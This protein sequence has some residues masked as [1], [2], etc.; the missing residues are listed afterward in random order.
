MAYHF[1]ATL[2]RK[3]KECDFSEYFRSVAE[4]SHLEKHGGYLIA[5]C[6]HPDHDDEHPSFRIW[7]NP[8]NTWSWCCMSC[9]NGKKDL[10]TKPGMRN[11]GT[12]IIA[13]VQWMSDYKGSNHI[14]TFEEAVLKILAFYHL[15]IPAASFKKMSGQELYFQKL[16]ALYHRYLLLNDSEPKRYLVSRGLSQQDVT[17]FQIGSDGDRLIFPLYDA[18]RTLKGF[19]SRTVCGEEPKYIHSSA[20]EGFIKSE[21]LYGLYKFDHSIH[22]AYVT[23]GVIDV[24]TATRYG[25][26][27]V[28]AC[29]GTSFMDSHARL[30]KNNGIQKIIFVFDGDNAGR[31][32][33]NNAIQYARKEGLSVSLI[34]LPENEDLDSFCQKYTYRSLQQLEML[35]QT[36]YEYELREM[37][38]TYQ[39]ARNALQNQYLLPILKKAESIWKDDEYI[40]YR[41]YIFNQFDIVLEPRKT[42][43]RKIKTDMAYSVSAKTDTE[44]K[45]SATA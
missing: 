21:F 37:S 22:T 17:T 4:D 39:T 6:P 2:L 42:N 11:Y 33:L 44:T 20:R 28:C 1:D 12:D 30:L 3:I 16:A 8:D 31:K 5:H 32:A 35:T 15:P 19:I 45:T 40:M 43:V 18:Q 26:K 10:T 7:H 13:F 38:R 27:N 9:H 36:D 34:L 41:N 29:L 14:L 23:E 24:I 25:I